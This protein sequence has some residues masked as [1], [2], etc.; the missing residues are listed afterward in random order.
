M[1]RVYR[2]FIIQC[3]SGKESRSKP[4]V[5]FCCCC[6]SFSIASNSCMQEQCLN[7]I[8]YLISI[9]ENELTY[10]VKIFHSHSNLI[11]LEF[12]SGKYNPRESKA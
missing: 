4:K 12:I 5:I 3:L 7:N 6:N 9:L 11:A 1:L 2:K 10:C 8:P